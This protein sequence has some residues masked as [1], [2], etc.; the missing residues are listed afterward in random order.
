MMFSRNLNI[1]KKQTQHLSNYNSKLDNFI[2][3]TIS[4]IAVN[5]RHTFLLLQY[6]TSDVYHIYLVC[7]MQISQNTGLPCGL[8]FKW[9]RFVS[10]FDWKFKDTLYIFCQN[11]FA[12]WMSHTFCSGTNSM[13]R[14][15]ENISFHSNL[16]N[17]FSNAS[18]DSKT[19]NL[20]I[21]NSLA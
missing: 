17:Q 11:I 9:Q 5:S 18:Y 15:L 12:Y 10:Q 4:Q 1:I 2:L 19:N 8:T 16:Q 13:K 3:I 20:F 6:N 7:L 14:A 21:W